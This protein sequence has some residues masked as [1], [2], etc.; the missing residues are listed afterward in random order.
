VALNDGHGVYDSFVK[1][2]WLSSNCHMVVVGIATLKQFLSGVFMSFQDRIKRPTIGGINNIDISSPAEVINAMRAL[3][4]LELESRRKQGEP[5]PDK[6]VEAT[7]STWQTRPDSPISI[8]I[9]GVRRG[10]PPTAE[11]ARTIEELGKTFISDVVKGAGRQPSITPL[12][13]SDSKWR[14][15]TSMTAEQLAEALIN[16]QK[17]TGIGG[18]V[19]RSGGGS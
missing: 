4:K 1:I 5:L 17:S 11:E 12:T 9:T 13:I 3:F 7:M 14:I 18:T 16:R 15:D 8:D 10:S 6:L 19:G 2:R